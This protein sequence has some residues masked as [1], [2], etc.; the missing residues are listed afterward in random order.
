MDFDSCSIFLIFW[1]Y[2]Y[3]QGSHRW[4]NSGI[5]NYMVTLKIKSD[6]ISVIDLLWPRRSICWSPIP[7]H[8]FM[9]GLQYITYLKKTL[10]ICRP[11]GFLC[12]FYPIEVPGVTSSCQ[13]M[14]V[15]SKGDQWLPGGAICDQCDQ[16]RPAIGVF[17]VVFGPNFFRYY[18][19]KIF[20]WVSWVKKQCVFILLGT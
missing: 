16:K 3:C 13:A 1:K 18:K 15:Y 17:S 11:W 6:P 5:Y 12:D 7:T 2:L 8:W 14:P 20:L 19:I 4:A 10:W 9:R